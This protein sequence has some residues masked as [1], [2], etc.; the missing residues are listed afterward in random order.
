V[1]RHSRAG[2]QRRRNAPATH[3][4]HHHADIL[5]FTTHVSCLLGRKL[6]HANVYLSPKVK[7]WFG[8]ALLEAEVTTRSRSAGSAISA[9][10]F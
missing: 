5:N 2:R 9:S 1:K 8:P 3:G 4:F 10:P 6:I 7:P